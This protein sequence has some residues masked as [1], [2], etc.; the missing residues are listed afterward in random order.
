MFVGGVTKLH[1]Y[2]SFRPTSKSGERQRAKY[3]SRSAEH[4]CEAGVKGR[5][6]FFFLDKAKSLAFYRLTASFSVFFE[7][8]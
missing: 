7:G 1:I 4:T 2:S 6:G 8:L 5:S 3:S